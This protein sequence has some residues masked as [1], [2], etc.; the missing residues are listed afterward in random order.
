[1]ATLQDLEKDLLRDC[2]LDTKAAERKDFP[3]PDLL[4]LVVNDLQAALRFLN[5]TSRVTL[6][7]L[8]YHVG[9]WTC[10]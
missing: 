7:G 5:L 8:S 1:M 9:W 4:I 3:S 6:D 10:A 2:V